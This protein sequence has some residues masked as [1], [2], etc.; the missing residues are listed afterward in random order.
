ME[1]PRDKVQTPQAHEPA[2]QEE[3]QRAPAPAPPGAAEQSR[4]AAV[5]EPQG[6]TQ[7]HEQQR[8]DESAAALWEEA[9][10][11]ECARR[12]QRGLQNCSS[13]HGRRCRIA[14]KTTQQHDAHALPVSALAK[15]RAGQPVGCRQLGLRERRGAPPE[16]APGHAKAPASVAAGSGA[17]AAACPSG[18]CAE[19]LSTR[20]AIC[21]T[22]G[23]CKE[24]G[25]YACWPHGGRVPKKTSRT[26]SARVAHSSPLLLDD[27]APRRSNKGLA[28]GSSSV[29]RSIGGEL[30]DSV[31]AHL[32]L[33]HHVLL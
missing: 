14:G 3:Q 20:A 31:R 6:T 21:N 18:A 29:V 32:V 28:P 24:E 26:K 33:N 1:Q 10:A 23:G 7:S 22:A 19:K 8:A 9:R 16:V 30:R 4:Q 15:L 27:G 13:N 2:A 25:C 11:Q 12:R 5:L 17:A